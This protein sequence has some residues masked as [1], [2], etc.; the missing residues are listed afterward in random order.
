MVAR[1]GP[2]Y[3]RAKASTS[4]PVDGLDALPHRH[5]SVW[6]HAGP[7]NNAALRQLD[8]HVLGVRPRLLD[9]LQP[10]SLLV[11]ELGFD[12][13]RRG[14]RI[15]HQRRAP[16][17]GGSSAPTAAPRSRRVTPTR[18]GR[19]RTARARRR[20]PRP[21]LPAAPWVRQRPTIAA[22]PSI[23]RGST[24]SGTSKKHVTAIDV[25]TGAVYAT[26]ARRC[27]RCDVLAGG[28]PSRATAGGTARQDTPPS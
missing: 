12:E 18:R 20:T 24:V 8:G 9:L 6:P 3:V 15:R 2:K 13:V 16:R 19:H 10:Q 23:S 5:R 21:P 26:P 25:L 14:D 1:L 28:K 11:L 22:T 17:R 7:P 27:D 4:C